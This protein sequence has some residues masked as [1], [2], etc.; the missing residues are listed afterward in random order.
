MQSLSSRQDGTPPCPSCP[1][2]HH[3]PPRSA[4]VPGASSSATKNWDPQALSAPQSLPLPS[5]GFT[6]VFW[7]QEKEVWP[8][9]QRGKSVYSVPLTWPLSGMGCDIGGR[10]VDSAVPTSGKEVQ[11]ALVKFGA[12]ARAGPGSGAPRASEA[13]TKTDAFPPVQGEGGVTRNRPQLP[14][15]G[16][17]T[18]TDRG[19]R[20]RSRS[21]VALVCDL[22]QP[23]GW[24]HS[25]SRRERPCCTQRLSLCYLD[26]HSK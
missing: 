1:T 12:D 18:L 20:C 9:E 3:C 7:I 17:E 6:S 21:P 15:R 23:R 4:K 5:S 26:I 11:E 8:L 25:P 10:G 19:S 2:P 14:P 16:R 24:H 22:S 13:E